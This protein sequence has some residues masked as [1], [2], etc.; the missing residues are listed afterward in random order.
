MSDDDDHMSIH[1]QPDYSFRDTPEYDA[2]MR[3]VYARAEEI[4]QDPSDFY[5]H[6]PPEEVDFDEWRDDPEGFVDHFYAEDSPDFEDVVPG[7]DPR[8]AEEERWLARVQEVLRQHGYDPDEIA[9]G[10]NEMPGEDSDAGLLIEYRLGSTDPDEAARNLM[11]TFGEPGDGGALTPEQLRAAINPPGPSGQVVFRPGMGDRPEMNMAHLVS[12]N[13]FEVLAAGPSTS[14]QFIVYHEGRMV[15][16]FP[17]LKAA[18]A[19]VQQQ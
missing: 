4:G 18:K 14:R 3:R 10:M 6:E 9:Q 5:V 13:G 7:A 16:S 12:S 11:A 2:W 17:S 19:W 15:Q 1:P 8:D